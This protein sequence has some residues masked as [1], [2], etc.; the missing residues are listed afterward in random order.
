[1]TDCEDFISA[2]NRWAFDEQKDED[3]RLVARFAYSRMSG[4]VMRL[5][6]TLDLEVQGSWRLLRQ[7]LLAQYPPPE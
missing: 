5:Y 4:A 6:D 7:A 2:V 3:D 1:M